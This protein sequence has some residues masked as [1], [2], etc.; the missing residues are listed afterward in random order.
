MR[1]VEVQPERLTVEGTE[2][3]RRGRRVHE[4]VAGRPLVVG[5]DHRAVLDADPDAGVGSLSDVSGHT[6]VSG[7]VLAVRLVLV[8]ADERVDD[9]H[10]ELGGRR[11]HVAEVLDHL[12]PMGQVRV[13]RIGV[14]QPGDLDPSLDEVTDDLLVP[15]RRARAVVAP[16]GVAPGRAVGSRPAGDLEHREAVAAAQ[17]ATSV[18]GVSGK[19]AVSNPI[20]M[21]SL[22][23]SQAVRPW[24]TCR[25]GQH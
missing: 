3:V 1:R 2:H 9:G 21:K 24:S 4:V 15:A 11:E 17:S 16:P 8:V 19:A 10:P 25:S 12:G 14:V 5:E 22:L 20:R 6:L 23:S 13:Q 7:E 18:G